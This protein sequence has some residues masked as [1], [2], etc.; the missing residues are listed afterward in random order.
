MKN[1]DHV[2]TLISEQ[3]IYQ[4]IKE[5]AGKIS[6]ENPSGNTILVCVLKGAFLFA[7]DLCRAT[8]I[9]V[10]IDFITA[11]SYSGTKSSGDVK[12]SAGKPVDYD[13]KHVVIIEDIVDTGL[14]MKKICEHFEALGVKSVK[15]AALLSKAAHR[16]HTVEIDYCGFDIEDNFV[17]GYGLD[18]N[19]RF[20]DLPFIGVYKGPVD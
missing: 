20:R 4:R 12:I 15:T 9:Q 1:P 17:V 5:L 2:D 11:S 13:G 18:Y 6:E 7:S 3:Q 16:K 8:S 14:T 19:Q 10:E